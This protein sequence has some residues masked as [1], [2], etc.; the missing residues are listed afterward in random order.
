MFDCTNK[1]VL[2]YFKLVDL[3]ICIR[4]E[5]SQW[6]KTTVR[7]KT[8]FERLII[9]LSWGSNVHYCRKTG[10]KWQKSFANDKKLLSYRPKKQEK[11]NDRQH[12][13]QY[14]T[15]FF[16]QCAIWIE[17]SAE[18]SRKMQKSWQNPTFFVV[19]WPDWAVEI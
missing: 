8:Y 7:K 10:G 15:V 2:P 5:R 13:R 12:F 9:N 1:N 16:L 11:R 3:G 17:I 4:M 18:K 19:H 14:L 6:K